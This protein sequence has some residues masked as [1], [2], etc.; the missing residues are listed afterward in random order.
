[1]TA[2][3]TITT[4][5]IKDALRVLNSVDK[6]AR[7]AIT[8]EYKELVNPL[9][10]D[11]QTLV[12]QKAPLSGMNRSWTPEGS[13]YQV[14][15]FDGNSKVSRPPKVPARWQQTAS[16]RRQMGKWLQWQAGIKAYVSGKRPITSGSYT[17]NLAAFGV[18]W[19]GPA[20]VLFD[21]SGQSKTPQGARMVAALTARYGSPSR[22][23]WRAY[24]QADQQV[25]HEI[26]KLMKRVMQQA[27]QAM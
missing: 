27:S 2:D 9:V 20:A 7:R 13:S 23:M 22:V 1:M 14:L 18:R 16:G 3:V 15:P 12:P 6:R 24:E 25:Q 10:K 5:G 11:A 8:T 21:T 17:R 26:E 4:A 19:Q